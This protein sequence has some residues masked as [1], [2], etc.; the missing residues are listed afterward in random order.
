VY[1]HVAPVEVLGHEFFYPW[2]RLDELPDE[3][4][5]AL[6]RHWIDVNLSN[7]LF[8]VGVGG[9]A[10]V[11]DAFDGFGKVRGFIPHQRVINSI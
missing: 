10:D 8:L 4:M 9:D 11:R 7:V 3:R 6:C 5:H 2:R 1:T